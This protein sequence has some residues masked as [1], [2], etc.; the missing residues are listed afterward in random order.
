[1][2]K[3]PDKCQ[4]C[5]MMESSKHL[6]LDCPFAQTV[7]HL[8]PLGLNMSMLQSEDFLDCWNSIDK[9]LGSLDPSGNSVQM[10]V[11][12]LWRLWKNRNDMIFNQNTRSESQT[13]A[14]GL[15]DFNEHQSTSINPLLTTHKVSKINP[16]LDIGDFELSSG[17]SR[18]GRRLFLK[19]I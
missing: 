13:V 2:L 10:V 8:S 17:L 5:D 18:I 11:F 12:L 9:D 7:W 4:R 16:P 3:L 14:K 19:E 6:F 1:M 15:E